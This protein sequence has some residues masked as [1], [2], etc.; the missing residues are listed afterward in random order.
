MALP[1]RV[2]LPPQPEVTPPRSLRQRLRRRTRLS[3]RNSGFARPAGGSADRAGPWTPASTCDSLRDTNPD[4]AGI[5]A[6]WPDL[7]PHIKAAVLALV[8]LARHESVYRGAPVVLA[9]E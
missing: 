8:G 6:A 5:I 1:Q 4:L 2:A 7:P 3:G 9:P